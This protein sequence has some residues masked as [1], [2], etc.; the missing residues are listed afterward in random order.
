MEANR[1]ELVALLSRLKPALRGG[2]SLP[3]FANVW[4]DG[5]TATAYDGGF[6]IRLKCA[7]DLECGVPGSALLGLLSTS[8]LAG[9]VLEPN[10]KLMRITRQRTRLGTLGNVGTWTCRPSWSGQI[11]GKLPLQCTSKTLGLS[12]RHRRC[13]WRMLCGSVEIGRGLVS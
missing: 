1:E 7:S 10:G 3:S 4:F 12:T 9:V 11:I 13:M 8:V 2:S 6:G 5:H